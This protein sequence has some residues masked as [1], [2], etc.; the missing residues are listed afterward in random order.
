MRRTDESGKPA[1]VP[2]VHDGAVVDGGRSGR[3][4]ERSR[5]RTAARS[6]RSAGSHG[7]SGGRRHVEHRERFLHQPGARSPDDPG[8]TGPGSDDLADVR[9]R[10]QGPVAGQQPAA[11]GQRLLFGRGPVRVVADDVH[12]ERL[13][14]RSA[15]GSVPGRPVPAPCRSPV[16]GRSDGEGDGGSARRGNRRSAIRLDRADLGRRYHCRTHPL[17]VSEP[18]RLQLL[19]SGRVADLR[20]QPEVGVRRLD[21]VGG[22]GPVP[23]GG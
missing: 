7:H 21:L 19:R 2:P 22:E 11:G 14:A 12:P 3:G 17:H 8:R 16:P 18:R 4:G 10:V 1:R 23:H 13:P 5:G 6:D 9:G 15:D 20:A